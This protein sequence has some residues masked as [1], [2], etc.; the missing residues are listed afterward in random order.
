MA[1]EVRVVQEYYIMSRNKIIARA[2]GDVFLPKYKDKLPFYLKR[3]GDF[4]GWLESRAI[5]GNRANAKL[6]KKAL[7]LMGASEAQVVLRN[8]GATITDTYW[9]LEK[10]GK[11]T[12]EDVN[13]RDNS[14]DKLALYGDSDSFNLEGE[15]T[16][17]LTNIGSFEKCWRMI[18]GEWYLY[19]K[20]NELE[21][22]SELFIYNLGK[23]LGF[24]M[25]EYEMD[26][27]YIRSK[28]F[29]NGASVN[30]ESMFGIIGDDG[31]YE[32]NYNML[33]LNCRKDYAKMIFLDTLVFNM[34]RDTKKYGVLRDVEDGEILRFAPN[35]GNNA[36]IL[37]GYPKDVEAQNDKLIGL[38]NEFNRGKG[39]HFEVSERQVR[40]A[41]EMV[42]IEVDEGGIV[43]FIMNRY[44]KMFP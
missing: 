17:G 4:V 18:D 1:I 19:K 29:T 16:P 21:L 39:F 40:E 6:I 35:F 38:W 41:M 24:N 31:D 44:D 32:K 15:R 36:L 7:G 13:F 12:Y 23:I 33:P 43:R 14:F 10:D 9:V 2:K 25:A 27:E 34:G 30:F 26:G 28:D 37:G 11:L 20:G 22:F 3:T 42:P 5:D 8:N